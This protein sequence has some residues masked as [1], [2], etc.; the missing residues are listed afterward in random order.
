MEMSTVP[1]GRYKVLPP[2]PITVV[3][4]LLVL[5]VAPRAAGLGFLL[6]PARWLQLSPRRVIDVTLPNDGSFCVG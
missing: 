4:P 2:S 5:V 3:V 6:A 1:T